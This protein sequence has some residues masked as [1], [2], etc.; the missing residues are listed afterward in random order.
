MN[1][2][3]KLALVILTSILFFTTGS[4]AGGHYTG[5]DLSGQKVT[6]SGPFS[7]DT[8]FTKVNLKKYDVAIGMYHDQVLIPMKTLFDFDAINITLGLPFIRITP[9]HG[10]NNIMLGK[11]CSNPQSLFS[12][13]NFFKKIK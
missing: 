7:A 1:N 10:T 12:A 5:P 9:D 3:T 4:K 11:N 13:I 8:F 2:I 6:I